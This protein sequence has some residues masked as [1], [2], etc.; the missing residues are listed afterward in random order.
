[1]SQLSRTQNPASFSLNKSA[2]EGHRV[3]VWGALG[4]I[5][6]NLTEALLAAGFKVSV[7]CRSRSAYA[8]PH[9]ASQVEWHELPPS[10]EESS[11]EKM[12]DEAVKS[13]SIIVDLAGS[14]GAVTSNNKPVESL[15]SNCRIQL[16]FL[17]AC[18]RARNKPHVVFASSRL[19]YGPTDKP[20]V[21][22]DHPVS[23]RSMYAAHK[24]CIEHYLQIYASLGAI[25][26]TICRISN[27]YGP[28]PGGAGHGYKILNSFITRSLSG[29]PITLFGSGE[30]VRDFIFVHDLV[31]SLVRCCV[32]PRAVNQIFNL[33]SG[34]A[35]RLVDAARI[36]RQLTN[37]PPILFQPWP[38]EYVAVESGDYVSDTRKL[39]AFLRASP[40]WSIE[41]GILSTIRACQGKHQNHRA[42]IA[43]PMLVPP[44]VALP[45]LAVIAKH[46]G[47]RRA[48]AS[49]PFMP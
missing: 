36:V 12:L 23:P 47:R 17:Q 9:W 2:T 48:I 15:D 40:Q 4:L 14:S 7:L 44:I 37:G 38:E 39:E 32:H 33:G 46:S 35:C 21:P 13:A 28:D 45:P 34:V 6:F 10:S 29:S 5:G 8:E 20:L 18:Q 24:L 3:L 30:Q 1:M 41:D 42:E 22:E 27:A 31:A 11:F 25:T 26:Y 49:S 43:V 19:V 16:Q